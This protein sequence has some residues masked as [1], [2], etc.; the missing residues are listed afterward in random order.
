VDTL[1]NIQTK[2]LKKEAV[3]S[4]CTRIGKVATQAEYNQTY[5]EVKRNLKKD[6]RL[7]TQPGG[8]SSLSWQ[9]EGNVYMITKKRAGKY[10][11]PE[12]LVKDR[13]GQTITDS[14][15]QLEG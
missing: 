8:R 4:S 11:R 7:Y 14:E 3:T 12:R 6:K 10:C 5:R 13:Q 2:R 9:Y 15:Q 1:L